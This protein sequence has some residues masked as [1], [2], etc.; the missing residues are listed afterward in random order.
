MKRLALIV[1]PLIA[2]CISPAV[3]HAYFFNEDLEVYGYGQGWF[4]VE[5]GMGDLA[6][7]Y[8][9]VTGDE[10]ARVASGFELARARVGFN[11]WFLERKLGFILQLRFESPVGVLDCAVMYQP[12]KEFLIE[13]GQFKFPSTFENLIEDRRLDF[14]LRTDIST[15][16][17]NYGM[18]TS[19]PFTKSANPLLGLKSYLRDFGLGFKMK[20]ENIPTP[21]RAFF[22]IGNG[23]GANLFVGGYSLKQYLLS[24]PVGQ[25]FFGM[26]VEFEPWKKHLTIGGF[27]NY[28]DH[29]N[30]ALNDSG[31]VLDIR[32]R[33][34]DVDVQLEIPNTG[35]N[36]AGL[37]GSGSVMDDASGTGKHDMDYFGW[38]AQVVWRLS[39]LIQRFTKAK[40]LDDHGFDV[41]FRSD[42]LSQRFYEGDYYRYYT[43]TYGANYRFKR[44]V[45]MQLEGINR[46]VPNSLNEG[47]VNHD[48]IMLSVQFEV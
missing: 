22:M 10:A 21:V 1:F 42:N 38:E 28:N 27:F 47:N 13:F 45:K 12:V 14:I 25:Y 19:P 34:W 26:R 4:T 6:G 29:E 39:P 2:I 8:N 17:A 44:Y 35:L 43:F 15:A 48:A 24:N 33:S 37:Y 23:L 3:A 36:F 16:L 20:I 9:P 18:A 31:T 32:R 7:K 11:G 30:V 46:I 5:E 41:V 40:F